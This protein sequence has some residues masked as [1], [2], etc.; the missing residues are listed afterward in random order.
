LYKTHKTI[1]KNKSN[2]VLSVGC[3]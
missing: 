3:P 2:T 1:I